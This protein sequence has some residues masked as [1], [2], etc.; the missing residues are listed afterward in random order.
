M[1]N[2]RSTRYKASDHSKLVSVSWCSGSYDVVSCLQPLKIAENGLPRT[3]QL[4]RNA[5]GRDG[6]AVIY[7]RWFFV[8]IAGT[9]RM[10]SQPE[11]FPDAGPELLPM[12]EQLSPD[13]EHGGEI[14][15]TKIG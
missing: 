12:A 8:T 1:W 10:G 2:V 14:R 13:R 15:H 9:G 11:V 4:A 3:A 7:D 6:S 5:I